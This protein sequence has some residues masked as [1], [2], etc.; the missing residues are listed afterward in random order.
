MSLITGNTCCAIT[1]SRGKAL[2][3][4]ASRPANPNPAQDNIASNA[5]ANQASF[6]KLLGDFSDDEPCMGYLGD[7]MLSLVENLISIDTNTGHVA[8]TVQRY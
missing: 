4:G 7:V 3:A 2:P 8:Y 1:I 6:L 5:T